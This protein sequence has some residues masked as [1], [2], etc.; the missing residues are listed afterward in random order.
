MLPA[1]ATT[2]TSPFKN[3]LTHGFMVDKNGHK[4]SKSGGNALSVDDL[5]RDL[6]ADVCRWWVGSLPYDNDIKVDLS[7]FDLAGESYRK[8]RNTFR[9]LLGNVS[10]E[11]AVTIEP[12]SIDGWVLGE[13]TRL[14]AKV[15]EAFDSYQYRVAQQELYNFCND[16]LSSIYCAAVKDRLYCDSVDSPRRMRTAATMRILGDT[17]CRLIAPFL[18]H[19]ADEAWRALHG[20]DAPSVHLQQFANVDFPSDD[21][22]DALIEVRDQ[23]LKALEEAKNE[24]IDNPLD[25]GLTLPE[26]LKSFDPTDLADL[27]GVSRVSYEGDFVK[28]EDLREQPKCDRSWKRDGTVQ[29][30]SDGG[31]LSDRD[32]IAVGVE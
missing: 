3:V 30:R 17:L 11:T 13:L 23:A 21:S 31:L 29:L 4:M 8:V 20:D 22:W 10:Q 27:C 14:S 15:I 6:G 26:S 24:G 2:G 32:A 28:V 9:F 5:F 19:T 18:P 1:L 7:F 16:T 12:S 25:A